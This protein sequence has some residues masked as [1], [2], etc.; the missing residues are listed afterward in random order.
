M[1]IISSRLAR[2]FAWCAGI[3]SVITAMT[4]I[5][6]IPD[7][8]QALGLT[9][10]SG[11]AAFALVQIFD[12][13]IH[14]FILEDRD[15]YIISNIIAYLFFAVVSMI[16]RPLL[17]IVGSVFGFAEIGSMAHTWLFDICKFAVFSNVRLGWIAS[18]LMVHAL[19]FAIIFAAPIGMPGY[20]LQ[21]RFGR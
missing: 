13:R 6:I 1:G 12:L 21:N 11:V 20:F 14:Y 5:G 4:K 8:T 18:S 19:M 16:I 15:D 9:M 3:S 17:N 10:L 7:T 2:L